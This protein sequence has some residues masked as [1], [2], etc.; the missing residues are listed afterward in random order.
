M[1]VMENA[2]PLLLSGIEIQGKLFKNRLISTNSLPHY[3]Q[4]DEGH[5][6]RAVITHLANRAKNGAAVVT[7]SG[8]FNKIGPKTGLPTDETAVKIGLREPMHFPIYDIYDPQHQNYFTQFLDEV[9]LY[10]SRANLA[11]Q[12]PFIFSEWAVD[13]QNQFGAKA[14]TADMI[15]RVI[16]SYAEQAQVARE[17][18]F[19]MCSVHVAYGAP[20]AGSFLNPLLNHRRDEYGGSLENRARVCL[21]LLRAIKARAGRDFIIELLMSGE[22]TPGGNTTED[23]CEFLKLADGLAD[24]LQ[25]R[26]PELDPNHPTGFMPDP[27]PTLGYAARFKQ[28]GLKMKIAP[29]GGFQDPEAAE[30]AIR[31]GKADMICAARAF[32][33]EPDYVRKVREGRT[34]DIVPCIRCNKCHAISRKGLIR[35]A[36]SVNPAYGLEHDLH[37][38]IAP[39]AKVK[40]VAVIG[41]GPGGMEAALRAAARG[42]NV[43]LFEK[44]AEL[45][46][47]LIAASVPEFKWPVRL[48]LDYLKRQ[49]A[50]SSVETRLG[51]EAT[52]L[53]VSLARFDAVLISVG[54][55]PVRLPI[56]GAEKAITGQDALLHPEKVTGNVVVIGGGEVGLEVA[57][58]FARLG[59]RVTIL[60]MKAELA[61]DSPPQHYRNYMLKCAEE[62]DGLG[63]VLGARVLAITD[64]GVRYTENDSEKNS[65]ADTIVMAVGTRARTKA[66]LTF[67][68]SAPEYA[69]VGDCYQAGNIMT[70]VRGAFGATAA[71]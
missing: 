13:E 57:M 48:Y 31:E 4:A 5:P 62:T 64:G 40:K 21:D 14:F 7:M 32:I 58:H 52:P 44:G 54:A 35:T 22:D 68:G 59:H 51:V 39:P 46:G 47:A 34:R 25:V 12:F 20:F 49:I 42:H 3:I 33:C 24:I 41:G 17:L 66:I 37:N 50:K 2:Y 65:P 43:T 55:E 10:N 16:D 27:N 38:L 56:P 61:E 45:G 15:A 60:E 69:A 71:L 8:I 28:L 1:G 26:S 18:G 53:T 63:W 67:V 36:C 70:A 11:L 6:E 29:V 19:D 9:H 23:Y 30:R